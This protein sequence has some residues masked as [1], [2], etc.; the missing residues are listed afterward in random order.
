YADYTLIPEPNLTPED[1]YQ[2]DSVDQLDERD[3]VRL[4]VRQKW[5]EKQEAGAFDL[6]DL[7]VWTI[8]NIYQKPDQ[9]VIEFLNWLAE[10]NPT[11]GWAIRTDGSYFIPDGALNTFDTWL[12]YNGSQDLEARVEHRYKR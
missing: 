2:F 5:Q 3:D 12:V 4:G 8:V 7:D 1:L 9:D 6:V 11:P 10:I